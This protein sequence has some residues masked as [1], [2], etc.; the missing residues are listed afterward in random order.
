MLKHWSSEG[1]VPSALTLTLNLYLVGADNTRVYLRE[2]RIGLIDLQACKSL[3]SRRLPLVKEP[4]KVRCYL[5]G[6]PELAGLCEH[7]R[8]KSPSGG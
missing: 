4:L 1:T 5:G 7:Q 2:S 3:I 8:I 6:W